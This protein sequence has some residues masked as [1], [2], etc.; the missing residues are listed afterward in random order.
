MRT[1][2]FSN[3][4]YAARE[5]N[6]RLRLRGRAALLPLKDLPSRKETTSDIA[7]LYGWVRV[8]TVFILLLLGCCQTSFAGAW[9]NLWQ[10]QN[11]QAATLLKSGQN[12]KAAKQFKDRRWQGVANYR[13][14]NY[15]Q[16][17]EKF[18]ADKTAAGF[19]NQGN[20]LAHL[21]RYMEAIKAYDQSLK[22]NSNDKDAKFNRDLVKKLLKSK[23]NKQAKQNKS[24]QNKNQQQ[25]KS[26][27]KQK[28]QNQKNKPGKSKDG[29]SKKQSTADKQQNKR[30]SKKSQ[31]RQQAQSK[32]RNRPQQSQ[33]Q[34][35]GRKKQQR[36]WREQDQNNRQSLR[37]VADNPGG[38]LRQ[39][40]LRDYLKRQD[41]G[42]N[43]KW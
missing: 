6:S 29:K 5:V 27:N 7:R 24:P 40:F 16:S 42:R 39:K 11:Q 12:K 10:T 15:K 22:V 17:F 4:S 20:S 30:R 26:Q 31:Q 35:L 21:G 28:S 37:R 33:P 1:F 38:L 32:H 3:Y 8:A 18:K 25:K 34:Q 36:Q 9:Q 43:R 23:K 19:Y 13:A 2:F 41:E 14:A